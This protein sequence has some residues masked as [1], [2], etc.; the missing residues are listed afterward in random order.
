MSPADELD[1]TQFTIA[2]MRAAAEEARAV[3]K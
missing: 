3:G 2:E 1:T